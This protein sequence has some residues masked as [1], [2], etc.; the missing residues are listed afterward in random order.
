MSEKCPVC[1]NELEPQAAACSQCG[2]K[3]LGSPQRFE[4]LSYSDESFTPEAKPL[5]KS[6]LQ[7]VRGPQTGVV[8]QLGETAMTVGRSPQCDIFLN[9]MT[10]SREHAKIDP[11][12]DGYTINDMNSFNG[13]W[14]NNTNVDAPRKLEKGDVI[15]IGAFC[16]LYQEE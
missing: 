10:V 15:Q 1:N 2:F 6:A 7:V 9:D 8:F 3:L 11:V 5:A 12:A 4:P 13:V 16:L 14:I